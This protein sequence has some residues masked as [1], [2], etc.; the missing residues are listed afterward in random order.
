MFPLHFSFLLLLFYYYYYYHFLFFFMIFFI[1]FC[2]SFFL[3]FFYICIHLFFFFRFSF[4]F[5]FFFLLL[6][7][8]VVKKRQRWIWR[9]GCWERKKVKTTFK[10]Q[11]HGLFGLWEDTKG[12]ARRGGVRRPEWALFF[13]LFFFLL[14]LVFHLCLLHLCV[15]LLLLLL[16]LCFLL[17]LFATIVPAYVSP[18]PRVYMSFYSDVFAL[19]VFPRPL[20]SPYVVAFHPYEFVFLGIKNSKKKN[21]RDRVR[22]DGVTKEEWINNKVDNYWARDGRPK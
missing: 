5:F 12:R 15:L 8:S 4:F 16:L 9:R 18:S 3:V 22:D 10:M 14:L 11:E 13:L 1:F 20:S 2:F 6:F 7:W 17:L 21:K 19:P